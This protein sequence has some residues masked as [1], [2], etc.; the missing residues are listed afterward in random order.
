MTCVREHSI[1]FLYCGYDFEKVTV[2][3]MTE[4]IIDNEAT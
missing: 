1:I 4:D 3:D 2:I